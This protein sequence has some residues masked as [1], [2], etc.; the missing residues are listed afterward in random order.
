M[1]SQPGKDLV[2]LVADKDA[3]QAVGTLLRDRTSSLEIRPLTFQVYRHHQHDPGVRVRAHDFLRSMAR[4]YR[5]ALVVFDLEG[6]GREDAKR[7]QIEQE[8]ED[9]LLSSG[10]ESDRAAAVVVAP[11][12]EAWVWGRTGRVA[13]ILGAGA[14]EL[15]EAVEEFGVLESGKLTQPKEALRH[16]LSS[17]CGRPWSSALFA[18]FAREMGRFDDCQDRAFGKLL[19]TLRRWFPADPQADP[20]S[21]APE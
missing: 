18:D 20:P 5:R 7:E 9:R 15:Q 12:L 8:V 11:E 16:V 19:S 4:A 2:V 3:E 21:P 10:W 14:T 17:V 1:R 6:C 13:Q